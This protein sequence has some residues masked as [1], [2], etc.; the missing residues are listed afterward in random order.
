MLGSGL[1]HGLVVTAK[2]LLGSFHDPA[3]MVTVEYPEQKAP[4]GENYRSFPFLVFDGDDPI[5]SLRCVAC[6]VCE[7]ECP[8]QCIYIVIER[9]EKGRPRKKPRIF[10]IDLA[11]C[12]SCG[13][14]AETCPFDSIKMDKVFEITATDRF[15]GLLMHREDLAKS[16]DYYHA[17]RPAEAAEVDARLAEEKRVA[18]EKARVAAAAKAAKAAATPAQPPAPPAARAN[19]A[20]APAAAPKPPSPAA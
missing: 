11:V 1:L 20:A 7:N 16:N 5:D 17:I 4:L 10:D 8:P 12:M 6:K 13:I 15:R 3:R 18:E 19:S 14:C 2:N 9:D